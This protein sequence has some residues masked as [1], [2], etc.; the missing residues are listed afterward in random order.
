LKWRIVSALLLASLIPL[1]LV[2][3]GATIVFGGLL[4][5][6]TLALHRRAV[7]GQAAAIEQVLSERVR[8]LELEARGHTLALATAGR[9]QEI[10]A[11]L[12]ASY[13][14]AFVDLG[15]IDETDTQVAYVGPHDLLGKSYAGAAW[16][17]EVR[18][19]G[20]FVSDVYLGHRRA[21]H[22]TVAVL[23]REG[24]RS[25]ILRATVSSEA[26]GRL[27]QAAG[28]GRTGEAFLVNADGVLQTP[29]HERAVLARSDLRP[30][31]HAGVRDERVPGA[32]GAVLQVT[33]WLNGGRWA[34]VV[35]QDEAEVREPVRRALLHGTV[36]V[37]V[38]VLLSVL[39]TVWATA[40]LTGRIDRANAERDRVHRDLLRSGK[41]ASLGELATGVAHE[42][43]NPL[44]TILAEQTNITDTLETL[45]LAEPTRRE[46]LESVERCKRQILRCTGITNKMLKFGRKGELD[47][48][49]VAIAPL[50]AEAVE[51]LRRRASVAN[52]ELLLDVEPGLPE[53]VVD[54]TELEQVIVN[55]VKNSLDALKGGGRITVRAEESAR[56]LA[57]EVE[58]N[59]SGIPPEVLGRI[60]EPFFTTKPPGQGTGMGL[61]VC[62][63]LVES[64]GG[65]LG[66]ESR[67]GVGTKVT[68]RLPA[69]YGGSPYV[70]KSC[71]EVGSG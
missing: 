24:A 58:D 44:A 45:E 1:L 51:L 53:V 47:P 39:V 20:S 50:L 4:V 70:R 14:G 55:L 5:E 48:K 62:H 64:W 31:P 42:I 60:F 27:V 11:H 63:G 57:L 22:S 40:H 61:A 67:P 29:S 16:V 38:A 65:S 59:G 33:T 9:L 13:P 66:V 41:L 34:L 21:P 19:R 35:R 46:L 17:R 15:V 30:R 3:A 2:G 49:P 10:H 71:P 37:S 6:K 23:R 68:I 36:V 69:V 12:A 18:V 25:W 43:N 7:E 28:G 54:A 56:E 26:L 52:V 32:R 8:A